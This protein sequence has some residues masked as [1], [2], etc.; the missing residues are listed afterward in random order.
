MI[1]LPPATLLRHGMTVF[2][3]VLKYLLNILYFQFH[4]E[5]QYGINSR[6]QTMGQTENG[7]M[8]C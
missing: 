1:I 4:M 3:S 5:L 8:R 6:G 2:N 7:V